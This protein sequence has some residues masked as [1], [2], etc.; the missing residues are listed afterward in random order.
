VKTNATN[1]AFEKQRKKKR[2]ILLVTP[3]LKIQSRVIQTS[4]LK[5]VVKLRVEFGCKAYN[6]ECLT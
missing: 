6:N 5:Y 3:T 4:N 1:R 2:F